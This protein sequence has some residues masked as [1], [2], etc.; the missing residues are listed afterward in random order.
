MKRAV[1][2]KLRSKTHDLAFSE[3]LVK[4][5][6][7]EYQLIGVQDDIYGYESEEEIKKLKKELKEKQGAVKEVKPTSKGNRRPGKNTSGKRIVVEED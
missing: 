3:C 6:K 7:S 5:M 4:T 2:T 1:R